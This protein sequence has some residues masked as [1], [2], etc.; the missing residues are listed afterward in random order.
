MTDVFISYTRSDEAWAEWIAWTLEEAGYN[1][2]LQKWDFRPGSNFVLEMQRAAAQA[3]RTVVVLSGDYLRS[4]FA[5]P[6]WA[7]A[8]AKDPSGLAGKL[9]PVRVTEVNPDGLLGPFIYIDLVGK[10]LADATAALLAGFKL[11]RAK[12]ASPPPFPGLAHEA[13]PFPGSAVRTTSAQPSNV[14]I[15]RQATD[16]DKRRFL[17][18]GFD[19]IAETFRT[20]LGDLERGNPGVATD[21][22]RDGST[23]FRAQVYLDGKLQANCKIWLGGMLGDDGISYAE[24]S[25]AN[26]GNATNET[27]SLADGDELAFRA[28]MD[29]GLGKRPAGIDT[30]RMSA[31]EAAQYLWARFVWRFAQ[32]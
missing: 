28:L 31:G 24:G 23:T 10:N 12:P 27:I 16:L 3:S 29:M 30:G 22:D 25:T 7:A 9:V 5:A 11:G 26:M 15:R 17:R 18:D 14:R 8:F 20:Y 21:F 4:T 2:I 6:E 32:T 1:S 13:K 19:V